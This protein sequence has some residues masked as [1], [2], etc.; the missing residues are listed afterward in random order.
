[1]IHLHITT[2]KRT[3]SICKPDRKKETATAIESVKSLRKRAAPRE[4]ILKIIHSY[5]NQMHKWMKRYSMAWNHSAGNSD[6]EIQKEAATTITKDCN[7]NDQPSEQ[8]NKARRNGKTQRMKEESM[9]TFVLGTY[10]Y[11]MIRKCK[12]I[13]QI[14]SM[15]SFIQLVSEWS[16]WQL[17]EFQCCKKII[18]AASTALWTPPVTTNQY[19]YGT[20]SCKP[21]RKKREKQSTW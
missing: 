1:M 21:Q 10:A 9:H 6:D 7:T 12:N 5:P 11:R 4:H 17:Q 8:D 18:S 13:A 19:Y 14:Q 15:L 3:A 2:R 20:H 16:H